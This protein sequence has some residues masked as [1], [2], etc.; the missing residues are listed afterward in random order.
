MADPRTHIFDVLSHLGQETS[1]G[2][3]VQGVPNWIGG[4]I[5]FALSEQPNRQEVIG[6]N[7]IVFT[8]EVRGARQFRYKLGFSA[9]PNASGGGDNYLKFIEWAF[10]AA[11]GAV[12]STMNSFTL[13]GSKTDL[14]STKYYLMFGNMVD[15]LRL[16]NE[17]DKPMRIEC[18]GPTQF[19][20]GKTSRTYTGLV[21][22]DQSSQNPLPE[23]T[24]I[25]QDPVVWF[26]GGPTTSR[27]FKWGTDPAYDNL[28]SLTE[29]TTIPKWTFELR[30]SLQPTVGRKVGADTNE[31]HVALAQSPGQVVGSLNF[32]VPAWDFGSL[33]EEEIQDAD[34][35]K[36]VIYMEVPIDDT[37]YLDL[38]NGKVRIDQATMG[39][40]TIDMLDVRIEKFGDIRWA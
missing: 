5:S 32:Q 24:P 16:I 13:E 38:R 25:A 23:V 6:S 40:R 35:N 19:L 26:G 9:W 4:D 22:L 12:S 21:S 20:Q 34:I 8:K 36:E 28:P 1:Y 3:P 18:E 33:D 30:R 37:K 15:V 27:A 29:F 2:V 11:S 7:E 14:V 17:M 10:G 31:Y 39:G